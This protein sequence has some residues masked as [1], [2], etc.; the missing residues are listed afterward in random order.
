MRKTDL[1]GSVVAL[2]SFLVLAGLSLSTPSTTAA[3]EKALRILYSG[4]V[5]GY[6][7]PCG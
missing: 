6:L 5:A 7:E 4:D 2:S 1:A 3:A